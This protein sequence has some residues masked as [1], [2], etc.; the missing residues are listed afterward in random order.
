MAGDHIVA[1]QL[2]GSAE[3]GPEFQ[4]AV[5][6][7]AGAGGL[8]RLVAADELFHDAGTE[9]VLK[10]KGIVGNAHAA[11]DAAGILHIVQGAAGALLIFP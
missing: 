3:H 10:I 4:I 2:L 1:A 5:A 6:V 11:A 7:D 8:A 9:V